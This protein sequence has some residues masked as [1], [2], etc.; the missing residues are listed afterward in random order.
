MK[1]II[2]LEAKVLLELCDHYFAGAKTNPIQQQEARILPEQGF[3]AHL[4]GAQ[5]TI[6]VKRIRADGKWT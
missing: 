2:R 3:Q 1:E 6:Y 5:W 4:L